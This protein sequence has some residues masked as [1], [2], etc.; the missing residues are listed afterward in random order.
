M[1]RPRTEATLGH[2][3][4]NTDRAS[5]VPTLSPQA[6]ASRTA[7]VA[8]VAAKIGR[9]IVGQQPL[10]N[11]LLSG[12]LVNGNVLLEGPH[13]GGTVRV[14]G[15]ERRGAVGWTDPFGRFAPR[16]LNTRPPAVRFPCRRAHRAG[17]ARGIRCGRT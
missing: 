7:F 12:L 17:H 2:V 16:R 11:R 9:V 10:I 3:S 6:I 1:S 15:H 8:P 13:L 5:G 4:S 14:V